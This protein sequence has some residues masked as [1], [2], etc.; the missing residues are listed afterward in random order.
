MKSYDKPTQYIKKQRQ[1]FVNKGLNSQSYGFLS[2]HVW[3]RELDHKK[4]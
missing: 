1:H 4:G 2:T 3:M